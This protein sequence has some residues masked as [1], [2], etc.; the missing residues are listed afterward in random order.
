MFHSQRCIKLHYVRLLS[1]HI[2]KKL[3]MLTLV[4]IDSC[5]SWFTASFTLSCNTVTT[6]DYVTV[7]TA[8][9]TAVLTIVAR[10]THYNNSKIQLFEL[11]DWMVVLLLYP[12]KTNHHVRPSVHQSVC[13]SVHQSVCLSVCLQNPCPVNIFLIKK[14]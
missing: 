1:Y 2:L 10:L 13:L 3:N 9:V 11:F 14:H 4:T 6:T 5:P 12:L 7:F 8:L